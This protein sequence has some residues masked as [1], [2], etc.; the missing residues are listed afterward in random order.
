MELLF[1]SKKKGKCLKLEVTEHLGAK[2]FISC[3]GQDAFSKIY[4]VSVGFLTCA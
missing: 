1:R 3:P 2:Q 4:V